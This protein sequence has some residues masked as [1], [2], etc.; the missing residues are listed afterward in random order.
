MFH[1][2]VGPMCKEAEAFLD[3]LDYPVEEHLSGEK[4]F[5]TLLDRYRVKFPQTEGVSDSYE[6]FPI[7]FVGDRAFSGFDEEVRAAIDEE[8]GK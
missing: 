3:G 2:G 8:I 1:N 7:I 5:L 6:Y 4:N